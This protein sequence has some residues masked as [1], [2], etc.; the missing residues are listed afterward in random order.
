MPSKARGGLSKREWKIAHPGQPVP[1]DKKKKG[2]VKKRPG[3]DLS[4][5]KVD[6]SQRDA[7]RAKFTQTLAPT[8]EEVKAQTQ[9]ENIITS[10]ELGVAAVER[11]PIA[12]TFVTGQTKALEKSAALKSLPLQTRLANLQAR[13]QTASDL[14]KAQL[15]YATEDVISQ[16]KLAESARE[17][18]LAR[19]ESEAER[20]FKL[21][22]FQKNVRQFNIS[23]AR[24]R[25]EDTEKDQNKRDDDFEKEARD[26]AN[27]VFSGKLNRE[28]A[29][30]RLKKLYP[31]Y[32]EN[33]I[34]I[35][36]PD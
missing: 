23:E 24:N 6:T 20:A 26:L 17:S 19:E 35:L 13:R 16:R 15:G 22:E 29:K 31:E 25:S 10:K 32:D 9:L 8:P 3:V 7:L 21:K 27:L 1:S 2:G 11:E 18:M 34:Y 4:I 36:V 5:P 30:D 28:Q 33:I 14:L 12:Q